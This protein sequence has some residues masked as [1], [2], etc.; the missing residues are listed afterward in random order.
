MKP[1]YHKY[2]GCLAN[3]TEYLNSIEQAVNAFG[4]FTHME[5]Y[6]ISWHIQNLR[7]TIEWYV[8]PKINIPGEQLSNDDLPPPG[9]L[10]HDIVNKKYKVMKVA[11]MKL[12]FPLVDWS[13]LL[14]RLVGKPVGDEQTVQVYFA[15]YFKS[16]FKHLK[17][18]PVW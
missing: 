17:S 5:T 14:S 8:L 2:L 4:D 12:Q 7:T 1:L 6:N 13:V 16:L 10:R 9:Q 3:Y 18:L 15:E 11:E